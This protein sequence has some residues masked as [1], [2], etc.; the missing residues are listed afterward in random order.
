MSKLSDKI[1][2]DMRA[3]LESDECERVFGTKMATA[4]TEE[5]SCA[6]HDHSSEEMD[7]RD[8]SSEEDCGDA[9]DHKDEE[10]CDM[11]EDEKVSVALSTALAS[12]LTAS[13]ALDS[14]G[15]EKS[16]S[17]SLDVANFIS[18][19]KKK[20][21]KKPSKATF[22][23]FPFFAKKTTKKDDSSCKK[24]DSSKSKKDSSK[25]SSSASSKKDS[26]KD[27]KTSKK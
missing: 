9:T 11:A 8:H 13:A 18:E 15:F 6:A 20:L 24:E 5:D 22:K 7:A 12:L 19:A 16:A 2:S 23:K 21:V 14:V 1:A 3:Y 25:S 10:D 17:L 26:T 27:S 4:S